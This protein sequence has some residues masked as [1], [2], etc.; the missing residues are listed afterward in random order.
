MSLESI[1]MEL[2][3]F[4]FVTL[5]SLYTHCC[6]GWSGLGCWGGAQHWCNVCCQCQNSVAAGAPSQHKPFWCLPES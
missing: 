2:N 3:F 5:Y 1:D 4:F 6:E